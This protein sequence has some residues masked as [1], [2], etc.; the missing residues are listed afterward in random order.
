L[1][2]IP[3]PADRLNASRSVLPHIFGSSKFS[4]FL[5]FL[6]LPGREG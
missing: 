5:A 6:P 2:Y 1:L 3:F 4:N